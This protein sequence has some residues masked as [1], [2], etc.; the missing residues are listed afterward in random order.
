MHYNYC[1]SN[2]KNYFTRLHLTHSLQPHECFVSTCYSTDITLK[3]PLIH[4]FI[5]SYHANF[6]QNF[7]R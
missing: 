5:S 2:Y 6:R 1:I 7:D 3:Q 4:K